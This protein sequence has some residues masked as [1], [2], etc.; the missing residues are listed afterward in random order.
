MANR[1]LNFSVGNNIRYDSIQPSKGN[2]NN[3]MPIVRDVTVYPRKPIGHMT[4]DLT[5]NQLYV[6]ALVNGVVQWVSV[7]SDI[8]GL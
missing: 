5:T 2:G 7:G 6:S 4:F 8:F 1:I 3:Q